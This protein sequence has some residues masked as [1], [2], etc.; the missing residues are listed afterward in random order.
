MVGFVDAIRL[1][2]QRFLD[3]GGRS[4]RAE[5]WWW[6]LV[7]GAILTVLEDTPL[8]FPVGAVL[9]VPSVTLLVRRLHDT[10]RSGWTAWLFLI[11]AVGL[12]VLIF[13]L[14][15]PS[16][17]ASNRYG[18]PPTHGAPAPGRSGARGPGGPGGPGGL[19]E[20]WRSGFHG[21]DPGP[22]GGTG[23][24]SGPAIPPPPAGPR[25]D[26]GGDGE[27]RPRASG[28]D[29]LPPPAPPGAR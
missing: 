22:R 9:L 8:A 18:P 27:D 15:Q 17:T 23:G 28:W 13:F 19:G 12:L 6:W 3:L 5:F 24:T 14:A 21:G 29:D 20:A 1:G 10:G 2:F 26:T 25:H 4:T 11:P 16:D 7:L